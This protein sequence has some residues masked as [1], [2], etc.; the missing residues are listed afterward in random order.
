MTYVI[1][2]QDYLAHY[3]VLRRSG[4]YP[5]GSG[6]PEHA[7]N[8]GFLEYVDVLKKQ[9]L[10]EVEIAKGMKMNSAQ[11]RAAKSI[12]KNEEKAALIS[13]VER[14]REKGMSNVAI[15]KQ[16]GMRNES[17]VRALLAPGAAD[18]A[19]VLNSTA[20]MLKQQVDAKGVIQIGTGVEQHVGVSRTKLDTA[21]SVL[22]EQGYEVHT[23]QVDQLSSSGNK[24]NV[25]V[26]AK[27]E[28]GGYRGIV[29]DLSQIQ[30]VDLVTSD[31]GRSYGEKI[32]PPQ[33]ISSKRVKVRY[34]EDGG[35]DA[36][37][38]IYL[39]PGKDDLDLGG[40][41]YAQVRIAVDGSHY[42]KGMAFYRD[43]LPDGV[44]L[45]FNTNKERS[46][47]GTNPLD[48]MKKQTVDETTGKIDLDNPFGASIS[49]Q[50]G[51]L[52]IVNEEGDWDKW[53]RNFSSQMLSKQSPTLAKQ[54]LDVT[55]ENRKADLDEIRQ[56]TN[57]E[58]RRSLLLK[59]AESAD[60]AA[61]HLKA[62]ALPRSQSHVILPF[63]SIKEGEIYAPNYTD[64]ER[65]ALVRFP[66]GGKFEIPELTVN[67]RNREAK[68]A[69]GPN[70]QGRKGGAKDAVG[71]HP[72]V[73]ERLSGAD[74]DGD[75]VLVIPNARGQIKA[76]AALQKL[77][78][79]DPQRSYPAYEGMPKMSPKTKQTQMGL[80]SN[81]I[82]DMTILGASSNELAHAVRH[83]MVVIDA[84][85]HNLN[86]R[87]SALD[88]GIPSLM[89][90]YQGKSQGGS[91]TLISRAT[92][93]I[94]V[95][96]RK[97]APIIDKDT[98]KL[99]WVET[100]KNWTTPDGKVHY[101]KQE[102]QKLKEAD[103]AFSLVSDANTRIEN[104]YATHSNRLKT[105][106][107]AARKDAVNTKTVPY[108][109]SARK[110]YSAE[111][112]SLSAK[113]NIALRNRPLER[114][115]QL[116]ANVAVRAKLDS[117]PN[118][119]AA[120]IKKLKG[121]ELRRARERVGS[122]KELVDI[123]P[124]EWAAI[125]AGAVSPTR[126]REILENADIDKVRQLAMPR[127]DILMTPV[128]EARAR[129]MVNDGYS[130]ADIAAA[131]G[132]SLSTV[133]TVM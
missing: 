62:A 84:E 90:K 129:A 49:R 16:L 95:N 57:P 89:K 92:S 75:T 29:K 61:V 132:V 76:E 88:N 58:V 118:M 93:P 54:Q 12:A 81:L 23:V 78:G 2:E 43:D 17:S 114:Q 105:L 24:T 94:K 31:G 44:D 18:K 37:G 121:N 97:R 115:A 85:K 106:A 8:K 60:S 109:E 45:M 42:L 26:L 10:S 9:G 22:M 117:N 1:E 39:R 102:S 133:K 19:K 101:K 124:T 40:S 67:N 74:F 4:R 33:N 82:T 41:R 21:I 11:L 70:V 35:T 53:S 63:R 52:N 83:S 66:H 91:A 51:A 128:K 68:Q 28:I 125:Q 130:Q 36:D 7:S 96:E 20:E 48:A 50:K 64:G 47:I 104:V 80:V 131:L 25:K 65:V 30:N 77:K 5:W 119:E 103:D 34:A 126:L 87:Q 107:N 112:T 120:E 13:Q 73:A 14:M 72:K 27:P 71:I 108:S 98:G 32:G 79:F 122:G 127:A 38:V 116:L 113:L 15:A 69:I 99:V 111:V 100:G 3:G 46:K 55:Y 123:T 6:G 110:A 56:L 86:Y 59:H